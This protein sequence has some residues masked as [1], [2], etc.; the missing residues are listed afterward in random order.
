MSNDSTPHTLESLEALTRKSD[1][2]EIADQLGLDTEGTRAEIT[3]RILEAQNSA[4]EDAAATDDATTAED[5]ATDD[6]VEVEAL[7]DADLVETPVESYSPPKPGP[8][9]CV[10]KVAL[11]T[12]VA[13][14]FGVDEAPAEM[15]AIYEAVEAGK[16]PCVVVG[17]GN[18]RFALQTFDE[19][20]DCDDVSRD[21][22]DG[23]LTNL[24]RYLSDKLLFPRG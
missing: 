2:I 13:S 20:F 17:K 24:A 9:C 7:E 11:E 23:V 1:V 14:Y 4:T 8:L 22:T 10:G 5:A 6:V 19:L 21:V 16:Q 12:V 3:A 18:S 15:P